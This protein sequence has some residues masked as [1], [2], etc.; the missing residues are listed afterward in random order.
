MR[1]V[2]EP[3]AVER[4]LGYLRGEGRPVLKAAMKELSATARASDISANVDAHLALHRLFYEAARHPRLSAT[5]PA[6]RAIMPS[7]S[8]SS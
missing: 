1:R 6:S 7:W 4:G 8:T 3:Y 2:L 5:Q